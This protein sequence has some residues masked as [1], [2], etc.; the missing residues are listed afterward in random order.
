MLNTENARGGGGVAL[1]WTQVHMACPALLAPEL[2][3]PK[4]RLGRVLG[5]STPDPS[6]PLGQRGGRV[7]GS[8]REEV[9]EESWQV[10]QNPNP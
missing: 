2:P 9:R 7:A 1:T 6:N 3:G 4:A 5:N 8:W 10:I